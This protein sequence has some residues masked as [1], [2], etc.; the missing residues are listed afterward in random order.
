MKKGIFNFYIELQTLQIYLKGLGLIPR[1]TE[2]IF[3][4]YKSYF[5]NSFSANNNSIHFEK[6]VVVY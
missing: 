2:Y 5:V 6:G 3:C 1:F 4:Q